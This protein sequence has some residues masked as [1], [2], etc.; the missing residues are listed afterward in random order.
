VPGRTQAVYYRDNAGREPVN[1]LLED[2]AR[3]NPQAAAKVDG[4]VEQYLNGKHA[5]APP[6]EYP[7]TS[8]VDGELRELRVR[9]AKTRYRLLYRRSGLLV[10]LLHIVEKNTDKLP[11]RDR[12][13]AIR[14][15]AEFKA[16]MGAEPRRPPRAAGRDA[17]P[18]SR[19]R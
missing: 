5:S 14:R 13:L 8:Q 19:A 16:R 7:I 4:Y 17:P 3:S 10:V 6:P 2:L 18:R 12:E 1:A 11:P 9:F 15:F